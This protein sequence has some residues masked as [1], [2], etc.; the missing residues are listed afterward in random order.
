MLD[1]EMVCAKKKIVYIGYFTAWRR[2][3]EFYFMMFIIEMKRSYFVISKIGS[4][5]CIK[6]A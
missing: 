5:S 6:K 2:Q 4:K 1:K 3:T